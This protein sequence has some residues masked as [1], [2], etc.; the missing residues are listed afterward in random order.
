MNKGLEC[1]CKK[2]KKDNNNKSKSLDGNEDEGH[3]HQGGKTT[4]ATAADHSSSL[5]TKTKQM[6]FQKTINN[7]NVCVD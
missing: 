3:I 6:P 1:L 4:S 7:N 2:K 5:F